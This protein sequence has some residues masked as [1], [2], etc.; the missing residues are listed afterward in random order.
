MLCKEFI[1]RKIAIIFHWQYCAGAVILLMREQTMQEVL[2]LNRSFCAVEVSSWQ[3]AL[4][5]LY[6]GRASVVGEDC[7]VHNFKDWIELSHAIE[8]NPAGFISTPTLK[9][10][11]PEV[12]ALNFFDKV[13]LRGIPFT[14][15]NIYLHY[16]NR[17]C[18]CG[19]RFPLSGLNLDHVIPRSRGGKTDWSNIVTSCVPCNL[20]KGSHLPREA[21][22][23][24]VI[25]ISKPRMKRGAVLFLRAPAQLRRSWQRFVDNVYWDAPIEE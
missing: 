19:K 18:Y 21:G 3:R 7:R 20:K 11:I 9:I 23:R 6:L 15:R 12:I 13:P 2:V 24:L 17:C 4:A 1:R 25:P 10:A 22:M 5:L 8:E 14:R 16:G